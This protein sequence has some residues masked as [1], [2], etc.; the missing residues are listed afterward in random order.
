M[1]SLVNARRAPPEKLAIKVSKLLEDKYHLSHVLFIWMR[2]LSVPYNRVLVWRSRERSLDECQVYFINMTYLNKMGYFVVFP[3][4]CWPVSFFC[5]ARSPNWFQDKVK[6]K[7]CHQTTSG[8]C[9]RTARVIFILVELLLQMSTNVQTTM[10]DAHTIAAIQM[11][12]MN[13]FVLMQSCH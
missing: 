10:A 9:L 7:N 13:V 6:T 3:L 11:E 4:F 2:W 8:H 1:I 12:V 5:Y